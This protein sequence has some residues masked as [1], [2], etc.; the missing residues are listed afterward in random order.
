MDGSLQGAGWLWISD[1]RRTR[2]RGKGIQAEGALVGKDKGE[3]ATGAG[4]VE[5]ANVLVQYG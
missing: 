1:I 3:G 5:P 4:H 2:S